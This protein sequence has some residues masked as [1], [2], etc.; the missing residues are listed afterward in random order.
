VCALVGTSVN[1]LT[2]APVDSRANLLMHTSLH[3]TDDH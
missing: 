3:V 1:Q 2:A